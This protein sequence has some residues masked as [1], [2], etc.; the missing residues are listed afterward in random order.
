GLFITSCPTCSL[1]DTSFLR[2]PSLHIA[3]SEAALE[4]GGGV[5]R[6][7]YLGLYESHAYA[8]NAPGRVLAGRPPGR[9]RE[10]QQQQLPEQQ[11]KHE[12]DFGEAGRG[13]AQR[14]RLHVRPALPRRGHQLVLTEEPRRGD[15]LRRWR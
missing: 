1:Y 3:F 15:Q 9:L 11:R 8:G 10:G 12:R 14:L 2:S 5:T 6:H 4:R 7:P 13:D